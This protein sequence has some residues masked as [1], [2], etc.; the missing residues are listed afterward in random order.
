MR[1][2]DVVYIVRYAH[3]RA[4][5]T[6]PLSESYLTFESGSRQLDQYLISPMKN[7]YA[8]ALDGE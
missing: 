6:I 8:P 2:I 1:Y 4:L 5:L 7:I 3:C